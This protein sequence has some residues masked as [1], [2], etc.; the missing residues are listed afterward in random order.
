MHAK[1]ENAEFTYII[2]FHHIRY[3]L[4][5]NLSTWLFNYLFKPNSS[6]YH[7]ELCNNLWIWQ[8]EIVKTSNKTYVFSDGTNWIFN[9]KF[10]ISFLKIYD[11][12]CLCRIVNSFNGFVRHDIVHDSC[13]F[14]VMRYVVGN[15]HCVKINI[16]CT[17]TFSFYFM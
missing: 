5:L 16:H 12:K 8:I 7:I 14:H 9:Y 13:E 15:N 1:H 4:L 11:M 2:I 6:H 17:H 3:K 10:K